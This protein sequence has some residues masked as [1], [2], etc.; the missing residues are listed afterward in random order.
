[1]SFIDDM[2]LKIFSL[3]RRNSK[4]VKE[5]E[6][7]REVLYRVFHECDDNII[8]AIVEDYLEPK[9]FITSKPKQGV[10]E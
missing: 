7:A 3:E 6:K 9:E 2:Q 4:L 1:M 10:R 5:I 8:C